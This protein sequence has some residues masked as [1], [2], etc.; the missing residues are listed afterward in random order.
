MAIFESWLY[1]GFPRWRQVTVNTFFRLL[2]ARSSGLAI[3][4]RLTAFMPLFCISKSQ[5]SVDISFQKIGL[6]TLD[7]GRGACKFQLQALCPVCAG[8]SKQSDGSGET[9]SSGSGSRPDPIRAFLEATISE[10]THNSQRRGI[11]LFQKP[12]HKPSPNR[13]NLLP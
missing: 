8:G 2:L 6:S 4:S 3:C 7:D 13:L 12:K 5:L 11:W 9:N 1:A 10:M